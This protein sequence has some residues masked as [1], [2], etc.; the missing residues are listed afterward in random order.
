MQS[1]HA[2]FTSNPEFSLGALPGATGKK[3]DRP[4]TAG[5]IQLYQ[6]V[7]SIVR[8]YQQRGHLVADLDPLGIIH[9][10]LIDECGIQRK[11]NNLV[12]RKYFDLS[13]ADMDRDIVL[14]KPLTFI[15]GHEKSLKL[16][17]VFQ[18]LERVY[19]HKIG[20]EFMFMTDIDQV[21]WMKE[22]FETPHAHEFT[23]E[24]RLLI[25]ERLTRATG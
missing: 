11:A 16:R 20:L 6:A 8:S 21:N 3:S 17:E 19:C 12:L 13:P 15:A 22:K 14:H 24:Q 18:R 2:Y 1:W 10:P 7:Q 25:L 23:K 4:A 9:A 5:D